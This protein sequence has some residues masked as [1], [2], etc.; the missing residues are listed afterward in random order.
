MF[1]IFDSRELSR[2]KWQK[3]RQ[4]LPL[5][6]SAF[7]K[8][9]LICVNRA[10]PQYE[11]MNW[12]MIGTCWEYE[13]TEKKWILRHAEFLFS[14]TLGS[15]V[16]KMNSV[17]S[18][19]PVVMTELTLFTAA[20]QVCRGWAQ[21]LGLSLTSKLALSAQ[22]HSVKRPR[23]KRS[24]AFHLYCQSGFTRD[25]SAA[26]SSLIFHWQLLAA[27]VR[28]R[29]WRD[30]KELIL[31]LILTDTNVGSRCIHSNLLAWGV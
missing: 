16:T 12:G 21:I 8:R 25:D 27:K 2:L 28:R 1:P 15:I 6:S 24:S 19:Q 23:T 3:N 26:T 7:S 30:W 29:L 11:L 14:I 17:C 18:H 5:N 13:S 22:L 10:P 9:D 20:F 31:S 4:K